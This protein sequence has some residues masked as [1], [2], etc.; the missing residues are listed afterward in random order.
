LHAARVR[1]CHELPGFWIRAGHGQPAERPCTIK[2][3]V[4]TAVA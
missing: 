2:D 1:R 3:E 4:V